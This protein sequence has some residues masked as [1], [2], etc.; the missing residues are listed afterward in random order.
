MPSRGLIRSFVVLW[1]AL[2]V[3]LLVLS[4]RTLLVALHEGGHGLHL[5]LLAGVEAAGALLF[6]LPRTLRM[7][8]AG[9]LF[10]I[11]IAWLAHLHEQFR[12][13]LL[14]YGAAVLF[15]AVHG[16][17]TPEQWRRAV[18]GALPE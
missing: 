7:G 5:A 11:A 6:L 10:A 9:L 14:V 3:S 17:L 12:W 13:D 18:S 2:G 8:A 15:V 1:W 4:V 16:P